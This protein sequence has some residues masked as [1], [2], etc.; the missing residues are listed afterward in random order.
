MARSSGVSLRSS[1]EAAV[2]SM[3]WLKP[4]DQAVVDLALTYA[5]QIDDAIDSGDTTEATKALYLGPHLLN[6]LKALGGA[7]A[8]RKAIGA[9]EV[10][11]GK[12]AHLRAVGGTSQAGT[13]T[14]PRKSPAKKSSARRV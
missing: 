13:P 7:P 8:D 11:S 12:L 5:E 9:E 3:S 2:A 14:R 1:V 6:A 10:V 4:S